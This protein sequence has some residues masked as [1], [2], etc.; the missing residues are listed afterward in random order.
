[1]S[2][3]RVADLRLHGNSVGHCDCKGCIVGGRPDVAALVNAYA[4]SGNAN[5]DDVI[6]I[7]ECGG[8]LTVSNNFKVVENK[9]DGDDDDDKKKK[10]KKTTTTVQ[11]VVEPPKPE[12]KRDDKLDFL[13]KKD[14]ENKSKEQPVLLRDRI[15]P[16]ASLKL[17]LSDQLN[18]IMSTLTGKSKTSITDMKKMSTHASNVGES[19]VAEQVMLETHR[20]NQSHHSEASERRPRR[21]SALAASKTGGG[22]GQAPES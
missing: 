3:R 18:T 21:T 12:P 9:D 7:D 6:D 1:M 19:L 13:F 14:D 2:T 16:K 10:K 20:S 11:E 4:G 5:L 8:L 22:E 17:N 15:A